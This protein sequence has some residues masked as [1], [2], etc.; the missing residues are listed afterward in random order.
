MKTL[1]SCVTLTTIL[2][3]GS[4]TKKYTCK[5]I[6]TLSQDGYYPHK[7]ETIEEIK[8]NSS[9]KRATQICSNTAKQIQANTSLL[10]PDYVK[11]TTNCQLRDY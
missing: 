1:F 5:C 7:T 9:K 6:T 4:C 8:K 10:W 2:L 11:V 3:F